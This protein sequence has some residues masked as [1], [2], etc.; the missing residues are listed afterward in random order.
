MRKVYEVD[1]VEGGRSTLREQTLSPLF[2]H[3]V[4]NILL[5]IDGNLSEDIHLQDISD[6]CKLSK[7]HLDRIF[8]R[9]IG[10]PLRKFIIL[11]RLAQ[12]AKALRSEGKVTVTRACYDVGFNDLSNFARQ[13]RQFLGCS[14]LKFKNCNSNPGDC[15]Y[16]RNWSRWYRIDNAKSITEALGFDILTVCYF[17]RARNANK[18]QYFPSK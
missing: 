14:A 13:F 16:R 17:G 9:E 12:A 8:R 10:I 18:S 1:P 5:F 3:R 15:K 11:K 2:S 6:A 4:H 7:Y